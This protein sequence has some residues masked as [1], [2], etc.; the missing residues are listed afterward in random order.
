MAVHLPAVDKYTVPGLQFIL[1]P[2]IN[3]PARTAQNR[4]EQTGLQTASF[5]FVR[6]NRL[7]C[8]GLLQVDERCPGKS[9]RRIN[10]PVGGNGSAGL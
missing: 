2:F 6:M 10:N 4:K 7:Q 9:G 5:V 1:L 3:K 8:S